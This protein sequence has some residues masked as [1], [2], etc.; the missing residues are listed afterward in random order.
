MQMSAAL[1]PPFESVAEPLPR[2]RF[3]REEVERLT[4]EGFFDGQRFEL[5][6]G[7]LIDKMGQN[8]PHGSTI[9]R[10]LIAFSKLFNVGL[11]RIQLSLEA[12]PGDRTRSVPEPDIAVLKESKPDFDFRHPRGDEC[13]LVAEVSDST[14]RFDLSRKATLYAKAGVPEYWVVD[15]TRR[16]LVAHRQPRGSSYS[17]IQF[18]VEGDT[19][20]LEGQLQMIA[21][22]AL[23]PIA[24]DTER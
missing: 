6:D 11:I 14:V 22:A 23:L 2:K 4:D 9:Q 20:S 10:L 7:D 1:L 15:L 16:V 12:A 3:T 21:V 5:I 17:L 8:P 19:V 13:I 24:P 18:F